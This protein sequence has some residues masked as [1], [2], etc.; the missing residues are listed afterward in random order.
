M[1]KAKNTVRIRLKAYEHRSIDSASK[2]IVEAAVNHGAK[3]VVGPVPTEK[4]VV[5]ILRATHKYKDAREQ[6]EIRTHKRLIEIIGPTPETVDALSR[7]E[8][9]SGVEI[10]IKL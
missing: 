10:E 3:K 9:P 4:Q 2:K 5:T 1:A 7:L 6:F 8:L